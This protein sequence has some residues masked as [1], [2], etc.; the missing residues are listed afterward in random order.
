VAAQHGA[1]LD[2]VLIA[3][4]DLMAAARAIE[5]EHGLMASEGGWHPGWGTANRIVPLGDAYLELVTVVD[6][7]EAARSPFG[8]WVAAS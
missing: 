4:A 1:E 3:V 7:A 8:Q 2:H 6:A 5:D